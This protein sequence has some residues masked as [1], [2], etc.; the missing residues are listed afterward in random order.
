MEPPA[1]NAYRLTT[2]AQ[3]L[4]CRPVVGFSMIP[5]RPTE[6]LV[7]DQ[8]GIICRVSLEGDLPAEVFGD[9]R[10]RIIPQHQYEEG[11]LG[12]AFS[13]SFTTDAEIYL[14]YTA[15][16]PRRS[17]LSRFTVSDGLLDEASESV[18]LEVPEPYGTHN[19][20]QLAF[21]P[22]GYLYVALG[23]GGFAGDPH[24]HG[25]NLSTLL[26]TIL[27]L[28]VSGENY[29][30]PPDNP[31]VGQPN[32]RPEIYAYGLR[33]PW[34]FSFDSVTGDLWAGD[35]GQDT[36]EEVDRIVSGGNYGWSILEANE[37]FR[38]ETCD[39]TGLI[40]PRTVHGREEACSLTGGF[41]YRGE[42]MP[43]LDGWYVYG[44]YCL[45][46]VWAL[47][48]ADDSPPV[49]LVESDLRITTFGVLPDGE[50]VAVAMPGAIYRLERKSP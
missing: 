45:G 9:I 34:R 38:A 22:D 47:N 42:S 5:G 48:T 31:F 20:G 23:D 6:A 36:W 43:E 28:D 24:G 26:G 2:V 49:L 33:N 14:Y 15:G 13:P 46:E 30:I 18:L 1:E 12:L 4:A 21:G 16:N 10:D 3:A 17:V 27:R 37:C 35:V 39:R 11:L 40:P 29:A 41:V 32:A 25:Q 7:L 19:G 44:D 50:L 8:D